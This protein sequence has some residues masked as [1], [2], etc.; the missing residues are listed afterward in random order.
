MPKM[1]Q[2]DLDYIAPEQQLETA[3]H[4]TTL[5][6]M[7]SFGMVICAIYN[8]GHSLI[9]ANHNTATYVKKTEMVSIPDRVG[10]ACVRVCACVC[11]C[12]WVGGGE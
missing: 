1:A 3:K 5:C 12:V 10:C 8:D 2:P 7:F 6:D 11:V 4:A 9:Q